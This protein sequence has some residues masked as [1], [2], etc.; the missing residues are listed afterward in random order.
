VSSSIVLIGPSGAIPALRERLTPGADVQTFTDTETLEALDHIVR[1]KPRIVALDYQFSLT[2]RGT[3]LVD[4]IKDDPEL[5]MCEV[6]VVAHDGALSRVQQRRKAATATATTI[7]DPKALLDPRGTRRAA[8][9]LIRDGVEVLVDGNGATLVDVSTIGAQVLST[10]M[11]KPNQRVRVTFSDGQGMIRC[12]GS[13]VWASFEMPKGQATRYRAGI[14]LTSAD[15]QQ[16]TAYAE[17]YR[18]R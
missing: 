13:I 18:K 15:T 14:E 5:Q 2:S 10:K 12:S 6:R 17:R 3:A 4:R 8:R 16:L 11:L 9:V 1:S 7:D